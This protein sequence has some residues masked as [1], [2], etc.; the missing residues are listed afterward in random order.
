MINERSNFV[1][2][3][4]TKLRNDSMLS[5][6]C[7]A[8]ATGIPHWPVRQS[9]VV[10]VLASV[11]RGRFVIRRKKAAALCEQLV[12]DGLLRWWNEESM[13]LDLHTPDIFLGLGY[14]RRMPGKVRKRVSFKPLVP[15]LPDK[16]EEVKPVAR[17]KVLSAPTPVYDE[18]EELVKLLRS[19][20]QEGVLEWPISGRALAGFVAVA[21]G[22]AEIDPLDPRPKTHAMMKRLPNTGV[23]EKPSGEDLYWKGPKLDAVQQVDQ[24]KEGS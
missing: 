21:V 11:T 17:R 22:E 10:D 9:E 19:A 14:R 7:Q 20:E 8:L 13:I 2:W 23:V 1:D 6:A 4:L 5:Q 18:L 24:K 15:C 16:K 3:F 12:R